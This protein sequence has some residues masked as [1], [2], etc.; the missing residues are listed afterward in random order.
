MPYV[1][2]VI[3]PMYFMA[4]S[5]PNE[6]PHVPWFQKPG[7]SG[8]T[9]SAE[10]AESICGKIHVAISPLTGT[11]CIY[12]VRREKHSLVHVIPQIGKQ[13]VP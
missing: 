12:E 11:V 3:D 10:S 6:K 8:D 4:D 5:R 2:G 13:F 7:C 1:G 9:R